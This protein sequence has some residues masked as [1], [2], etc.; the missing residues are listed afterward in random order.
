MFIYFFSVDNGFDFRLVAIVVVVPKFF[1]INV[2]IV[3]YIF[4]CIF[5]VGDVGSIWNLFLMLGS[6]FSCMFLMLFLMRL[7]VLVY[8][9]T[10][11]TRTCF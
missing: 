4:A 9:Y 2:F 10:S 3:V 11:S 8:K 1:L 6:L 7:F 5:F